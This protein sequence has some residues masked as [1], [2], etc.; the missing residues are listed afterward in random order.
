MNSRGEIVNSDEGEIIWDDD[1]EMRGQ[2]AD[3]DGVGLLEATV[4]PLGLPGLAIQGGAQGNQIFAT[5]LR[6]S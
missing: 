6:N 2:D 4:A 5:L 3:I 1:S